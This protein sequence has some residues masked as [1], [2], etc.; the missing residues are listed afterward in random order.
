MIAQEVIQQ[1][2]ITRPVWESWAI[3]AGGL[4][5]AA[6]FLTLLSKVPGGKQAY[7]FLISDPVARWM[8]ARMDQKITTAVGLQADTVKA[9]VQQHVMAAMEPLE[10]KIDQINYAVNNVEPGTPPIKEKV[11]RIQ[12]AQ[13]ITDGKV[14]TILGLVES[15]V[16]RK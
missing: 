5:G 7:K 12:T 2:E 3:T 16:Q 10:T 8:D 15:L 6:I 11:H 4:A 14:D 13:E 1:I 9:T